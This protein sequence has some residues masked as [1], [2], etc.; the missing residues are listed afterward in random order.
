MGTTTLWG[1]LQRTNKHRT[2]Q[3][4]NRVNGGVT[5]S[6][7]GVWFTK[8]L[9]H[10]GLGWLVPEIHLDSSAARGIWQRQGTGA[11]IRHL[12]AKA[13][14]VQAALKTKKLSLHAV[15]GSKNCS[16]IGTKALDRASFE[17]HRDKIGLKILHKNDEERVVGNISRGMSGAQARLIAPLVAILSQL[18]EAGQVRAD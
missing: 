6:S 16:G 3:C 1:L 7:E 10:C 14:W 5:A 13:L 4:I 17:K 11:R 12:E 2:V 18:P 15:E 8:V 9:S